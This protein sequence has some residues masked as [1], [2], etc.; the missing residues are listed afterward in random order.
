MQGYKPENF[1]ILT[2]PVGGK[3]LIKRA[4]RGIPILGVTL[5]NDRKVGLIDP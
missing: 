4:L 5:R 1:G 2:K 3:W